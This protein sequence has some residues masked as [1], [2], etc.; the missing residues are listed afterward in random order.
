M[1]LVLAPRA[2][3]RLDSRGRTGDCIRMCVE[4][5]KLA[6][7]SSSSAALDWYSLDSVVLRWSSR[8]LVVRPGGVTVGE[9]SIHASRSGPNRLG[10][11]DEKMKEKLGRES[12]LQR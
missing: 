2:V 3:F 5:L 9:S 11:L 7:R 12:K 6:R 10:R 8:K 4:P 1:L